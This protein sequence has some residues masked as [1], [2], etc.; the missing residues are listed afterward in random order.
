PRLFR[1]FIAEWPNIELQIVEGASDDELLRSVEHGDL[2]VTFCVLPLAEGPFEAAE[3][4]SDP[5][6]LAVPAGSPLAGSRR[7][8]L[9][10]LRGVKLVGFRLDRTVIAVED[11][12]RTHGV[13]PNVVFRSNDNGIVQGMVGAGLGM[14]LVP[15]LALDEQDPA[16]RLVGLPEM[17]P[18]VLAMAWHHDRYRSPAALAIVDHARAVCRELKA[19][20]RIRKASPRQ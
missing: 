7:A 17:P 3:L 2:D 16:I 6:V 10:R 11:L 19:V 9:G 12:L 8:T 15:R 4:M 1:R 5:Y 18:R 20:P 14:A 13:E